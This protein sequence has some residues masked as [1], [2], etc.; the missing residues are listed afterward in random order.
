M[1]TE[2]Q[3]T[4][5]SPTEATLSVVVP[6]NLVSKKL[7]ERFENIRK[8]ASIK[9]FRVG[10]AP[11]SMIK[12]LYSF[13]VKQR[14]MNDLIESG[15]QEAASEKKLRIV[16][17]PQI[18]TIGELTDTSNSQPIDEGKDFKYT[19]KLEL[20]P[21]VKVENYKGLKLKKESV[22][23]TKEDEE[24]LIG[25]FL[26]ERSELVPHEKGDEAPI[27]KGEFVDLEFKGGLVTDKGV[28][29]QD[30]MKGT[31]F[32]EIGSGAF[33]PGF[34]D[35]VVGMKVGTEKTF[36]IQFPENYHEASLAKK[37]AEF[38]VK[39]LERKVVKLPELT[40]ELAKAFGSEN[41]AEFKKMIQSGLKESK[42]R[43]L[44]KKLRKDVLAA[45][46]ANNKFEIPKSLIYSQMK[47]LTEEFTNSLKRQGY[48]EALVTKTVET[49]T[50]NLLKRA[51]EQV[52]ASLC[53]E[54]I[55]RQES[56]K[57]EDADVEAELE[58]IS[59]EEGHPVEA[60]KNFFF[61]DQRSRVDFIYRALE[62][63]TIRYLIAEAKVS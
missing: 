46:S 57:I 53:L 22:E 42:E 17:H 32:L 6:K 29:Y 15:I 49:E 36:R 59:K 5:Q 35:N 9:G 10:H 27:S 43:E 56:I 13:D 11:I 3:V 30:N 40:D 8:T 44:Q 1:K 55:A 2:Y 20:I 7:D 33:I 47:L 51:E 38:T 37:E 24:A 54:G 61:K 62:E 4:P 25:R 58:R 21:E 12:K 18:L 14:V 16:G 23:V 50:P 41:V 26:Q 28:E 34:E 52:K 63:K 45:V 60:V 31:R 48:P 39:A 19:A